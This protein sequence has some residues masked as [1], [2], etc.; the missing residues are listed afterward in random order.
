[1]SDR[2][3]VTERAAYPAGA[4]ASLLA[5]ALAACAGA[6]ILDALQ[7][8]PGDEL[9]LV[10]PAEGVQ[11]YECRVGPDARAAWAFVAPEAELFDLRGR[12]VGR[13]GAG[14][15]WESDDGSRVVGTVKQRADA[16]EAGAIPWLLLGTR[17]AGTS[18]VF[19]GVTGIQRIH[20]RGGVAP[21]TGC[22]AASAG[23]TA[24]VRYIAEYRFFKRRY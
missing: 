20:T 23:A 13:H 4:V 15:S 17:S 16:P 6:P 21:S 19:A 3:D 1:M 12:K 24:R 11:V 10:L 18:G 9:A 22:D 5:F 14:P 8:D 2:S 7:P